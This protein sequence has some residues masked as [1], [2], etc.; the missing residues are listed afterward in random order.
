VILN[1]VRIGLA[2]AVIVAV[3][4]LVALALVELVVDVLDRGDPS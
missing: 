4:A 2:L 3:L 1:V